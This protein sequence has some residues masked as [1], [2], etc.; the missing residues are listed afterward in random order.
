[1]VTL[2][3]KVKKA[4]ALAP[5]HHQET[6]NISRV[7]RDCIESGLTSPEFDNAS[8]NSEGFYGKTGIRIDKG[9]LAKL[10]S[11]RKAA[12]KLVEKSIR[13]HVAK[14]EMSRVVESVNVE[15]PRAP[16]SEEIQLNPQDEEEA[17]QARTH[18]VKKS[19]AQVRILALDKNRETTEPV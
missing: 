15:E 1:M 14:E 7:Y 16:T 10:K 9:T 8:K 2:T 3:T 6:D 19:T 12:R 13:R 18:T 5:R 11:T 17:R 4:L